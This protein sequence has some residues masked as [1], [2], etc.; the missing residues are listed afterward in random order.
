M[1]I[2]LIIEDI[3]NAMEFQSDEIRSFLNKNTGEIVTISDD[4]FGAAEDNKPME[5]FS[6]WQ[7]ENIKIAKDILETDNYLPLPSKFDINEYNI[8]ENFCL[9]IKDDEIRDILYHSIKGTG[10]F[11]VFKDNIYRLDLQEDWYS[12]KK[13]ALKEIAIEWC[14][15]NKLEYIE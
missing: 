8:M 2:K 13:A 10:A 7:R 1:I 6:V 4:E 12:F 11:R 3:I 15:Y 5:N 9:S 14:E